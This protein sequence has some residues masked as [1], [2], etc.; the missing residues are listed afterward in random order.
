MFFFLKTIVENKKKN[1]N[2][3]TCY[4]FITNNRKVNKK[5]IRNNDPAHL[6]T[7]ALDFPGYG[8]IVY[9]CIACIVYSAYML[10]RTHE[11]AMYVHIVFTSENVKQTNC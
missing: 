8:R 7:N 11:H 10:T 9:T 4:E 5:I 2:F 3:S 1:C 6:S